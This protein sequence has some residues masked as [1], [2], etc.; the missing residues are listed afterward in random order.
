MRK[1]SNSEKE[2]IEQYFE[3]SIYTSAH[4]GWMDCWEINGGLGTVWL[5]DEAGK[6]N[7]IAFQKINPETWWL[8]SF[9]ASH[10][11]TDYPLVQKL[12]M[13]LPMGLQSVYTI[14]SQ[15]WYTKFLQENGFRIADEIIQMETKSIRIS[16]KSKTAEIQPLSPDAAQAICAICEQAFPP[17]WRLETMEMQKALEISPFKWAILFNGEITGYILAD[18]ADGNCHIDRLAIS[19]D[20]Q[21]EGL[22]SQL[23]NLLISECRKQGIQSFSVNTN[24]KNQDAIDFYRKYNFHIIDEN[25]PVL[26]RYVHANGEMTL[27]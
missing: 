21:N 19:P 24:R 1:V 11:P 6:N 14:S 12:R 25:F 4:M 15:N 2:T 22:G 18:I 26:H 27:Q 9:Y 3:T 7:L 23:L 20:H 16:S 13:L 8:H 5:D 17:L 10:T